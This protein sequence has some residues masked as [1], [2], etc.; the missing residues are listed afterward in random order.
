MH[1]YYLSLGSNLGERET[2]L[3]QALVD[4]G[5][6]DDTRVERL[7]NVYETKPIGVTEQ[8]PF[9]N[10][11]ADV[12]SSL[13]PLAM[14][15]RLLAIETRLGRVRTI[16]FGPRT[17]DVDILLCDSLVSSWE[18]DLIIPHPRLHQRAF[19]LI[20]LA[21][22]APS[23]IHPVLSQTITELLAAV[24]G[25]EGVQWYPTSLPNDYGPTGN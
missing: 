21:E 14:M 25:K 19:V 16:R 3:R 9:L 6:L 13:H 15:G 22:L 1:T 20:P 23:Y 10:A 24:S 8:G 2:L 4:I 11:V 18:Q 12:R 17:I 5:K 7:S